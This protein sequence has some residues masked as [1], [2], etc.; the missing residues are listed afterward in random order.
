MEALAIALGLVV[1][2]I[3]SAVIGL[4]IIARKRN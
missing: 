1:W 4:I 3:V 2:S